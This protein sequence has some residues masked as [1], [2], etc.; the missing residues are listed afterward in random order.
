MRIKNTFKQARQ[1]QNYSLQSA[2]TTLSVCTF[3]SAC[4]SG[5]GD[6]EIRL[7]LSGS[8]A[9]SENGPTELYSMSDQGNG[10]IQL[11]KETPFA[12]MTFTDFAVSPNG[13][14]VA[15]TADT[16]N[17]GGDRLFVVPITGG[18]STQVSP[19]PAAQNTVFSFDWAP[20]SQSLTFSANFNTSNGVDRAVY[21]VD[22]GGSNLEERK[23]IL[24]GSE[25]QHR[26]PQWSPNG[27]YLAATVRTFNPA[28]N[29]VSRAD[30]ALDIADL[31]SF[32]GT[33]MRYAESKDTLYDVRFSPDGNKVCYNLQ[34]R[35]TV[36]V[37]VSDL[38]LANAN[39]VYLSNAETVSAGPCQWSA[40]STSVA[41]LENFR[42]SGPST[43]VKRLADASAP[44]EIL[45]DFA[46][47]DRSISEFAFA[48]GSNDE[49][50]FIAYGGDLASYTLYVVKEFESPVQVSPLATLGRPGEPVIRSGVSSFKWSPDGSRLTF[51][52]KT[53]FNNDTGQLSVVN[54]D[55]TTLQAISNSES[56]AHYEWSANGDR[57]V[58]LSGSG[59]TDGVILDSL[60]VFDLQANTQNLLTTGLEYYTDAT[61]VKK[62]EGGIGK[63][64][65]GF[66]AP[67]TR[68]PKDFTIR[69]ITVLKW[70][71]N[72]PDSTLW[73]EVAVG[74]DQR[75]D[76]E[77]GLR[78]QGFLS[79]S[80]ESTEVKNA[81]QQFEYI[82][83]ETTDPLLQPLPQTFPFDD[84]QR[85]ELAMF[86]A[87]FGRRELMVELDFTAPGIF[88][89]SGNGSSPVYVFD[90][91]YRFQLSV[92]WI[93]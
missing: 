59:S 25:A 78:K 52:T 27:K 71:A 81:E 46:A 12:D 57:L 17:I 74:T 93:Y 15:Y 79:D 7:V 49:L 88:N 21:T 3:L 33:F 83:T 85:Y 63:G 54:K 30:Y 61:Y 35:P 43:L 42:T 18:I 45:A 58:T 66:V 19:D 91:D 65:T 9:M 77:L 64:G 39:S 72:R 84:G 5:A 6:S 36:E 80:Y 75:P 28:T 20:D 16:D 60:S 92:E 4:G 53:D 26:D 89:G 11:S 50:A 40:D 86:D 55:G 1:N 56:T 73:D 67:D 22:V 24:D 70:P 10:L 90:D 62:P 29:E 2:L 82:F 51:L 68:Q 69:S 47:L 13:E 38:T 41:Y 34:E 37:A 44:A 14:L 31:N 23:Y 32:G 8:D 48:P 87:D 76:L